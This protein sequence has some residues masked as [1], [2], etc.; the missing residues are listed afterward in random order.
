MLDMSEVLPSTGTMQQATR[1]T[2]EDHA[3]LNAVVETVR[4]LSLQTDPQA[5]VQVFRE[6]AHRFFGGQNSVSLSRRGLNW[7][8]FRITRSTRWAEHIN[9]WQNPEKLPLLSGGILAELLYGNQ[10]CILTDVTIDPDDP[11]YRQIGDAR[12][13]LA[14]PLFDGGEA[15]N[16]VVRFSADADAFATVNLPD[17][18]LM[19]NLF[20]RATSGLVTAQR[21]RL[22]YAEQEREL[23]RIAE[24][25]RSLLPLKLPSIAGFDFAA[26]YQTAARAGGDY[27]DF[28]DLRDG[29]WGVIIA[30]VSGH[31]TP[32]A[33]VMAMFRTMLHAHCV[34]CVTPGELLANANRQLFDH[35]HRYDGT[36]VTA[37]YGEL[38]PAAGKFR[39]ASA[40]HNPALIV[41][42]R[43]HVQELHE[44]QSLPLAIDP[45]CEFIESETTLRAGDTLLLYTDGITEAH[46][47]N[48]EM[49]GRDRLLECIREDVPNAQHIIDC[50]RHKLM[51]FTGGLPQF[52]DQTLLAM[53]VR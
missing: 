53:R 51:A 52:D 17:A 22:T 43:T 47:S 41:D 2:I 15:L 19:A 3:R 29:R 13:M 31:G 24:I 4:E 20:G 28:F 50:V 32:A 33:V 6:R 37:F 14:M 40:G 46:N 11:A 36:F 38:D 8:Q 21:L 16:M 12:T 39:Y 27:Y 9:P 25:Q 35:S 26:W 45:E 5:L 18:M 1:V 42:A 44:A 34:E 48:G 30:D 10:P 7:P 23:K 49:Y